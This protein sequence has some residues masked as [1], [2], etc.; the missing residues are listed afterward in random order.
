MAKRG[1]KPQ[2]IRI[3]LSF[4]TVVDGLLRIPPMPKKTK[5]TKAK[6]RKNTGASKSRS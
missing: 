1:P 4:D 3:P 6:T 5:A 2:T